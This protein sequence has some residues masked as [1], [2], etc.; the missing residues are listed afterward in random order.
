MQ[1]EV[2]L[3]ISLFL[4][5]VET[6]K[7]LDEKPKATVYYFWQWADSQNQATKALAEI[8]AKC[9]NLVTIWK[10]KICSLRAAPLCIFS[11]ILSHESRIPV[12]LLLRW[13][14]FTPFCE[15]HS[16]LRTLCVGS[17][18]RTEASSGRVCFWNCLHSNAGP[19]YVSL[20]NSPEQS[21]PLTPTS[22]GRASER[23]CAE[24]LCVPALVHTRNQGFNLICKCVWLTG[25]G[26][27]T[28][29]E[30]VASLN[31]LCVWF[32]RSSQMTQ[33]CATHKQWPIYCRELNKR[34]TKGWRDIETGDAARGVGMWGWTGGGVTC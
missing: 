8:C 15:H 9:H 23:S 29:P 10:A 17:R 25:G 22:S 31:T 2:S 7:P 30:W 6:A 33:F 1:R 34:A 21:V 26:R 4:L 32:R 24:A 5:T 12:R 13:W 18:R 20:T 27:L 14:W 16:E 28:E 19:A 3:I 11:I